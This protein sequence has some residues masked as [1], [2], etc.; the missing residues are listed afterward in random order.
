MNLRAQY[1]ALYN[2]VPINA[3]SG[4]ARDLERGDPATFKAGYSRENSIISAREIF[5]EVSEKEIRDRNEWI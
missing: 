2:D 3:A 4:I 5:P 1:L